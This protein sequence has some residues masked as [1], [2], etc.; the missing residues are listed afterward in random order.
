M[1]FFRFIDIICLTEVWYHS[2]VTINLPVWQ[3]FHRHLHVRLVGL[4]ANHAPA[5]FYCPSNFGFFASPL[6]CQSPTHLHRMSWAVKLDDI[7]VIITI[8]RIKYEYFTFFQFFFEKCI[9][10]NLLPA[11]HV[12]FPLLLQSFYQQDSYDFLLLPLHLWHQLLN[13]ETIIF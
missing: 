3:I 2:P 7:R 8:L 10:I 11:I 6:D 4:G 12:S 1:L 13:M 5:A 9:F